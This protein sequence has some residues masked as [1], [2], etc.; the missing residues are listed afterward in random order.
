MPALD[1]AQQLLADGKPSEAIDLLC[2]PGVPDDAHVCALIARA[3]LM[4]GD[5]R[6]DFFSAR[7]FAQRAMTHGADHNTVA[8]L[9]E[10][11]TP[12]AAGTGVTGAILRIL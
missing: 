11:T 12:S 10:Q 9:L 3:Y 1:Q 5:A 4:R 2:R 6:G 8:D 7:F